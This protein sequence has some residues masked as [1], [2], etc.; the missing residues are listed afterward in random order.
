M[1]SSKTTVDR[2]E[3]DVW[4]TVRILACIAVL[5][6][7][8]TSNPSH[9]TNLGAAR[10]LAA[11]MPGDALNSDVIEVRAVAR[12]GA[13]RGGAVRRTTVVGPRG[14]AA[15]RTVVR[16]GAVVRPGYAGG[17]VRWA[18]P[19][20]YYWPRGGAIAAGAA[21]GFV[22][23]ATAAAWAGAAPAPGMCWYY[24]DPSQTQGFWDYC[25]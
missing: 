15:S 7:T 1:R 24:T 8:A 5:G 6:A 18:R 12:G 19:G 14:G 25:Q 9:A 10:L 2:R 3:R 23:A 17:G 21:I 22:T 4:N 20:R 16:G 13:A 11:Q